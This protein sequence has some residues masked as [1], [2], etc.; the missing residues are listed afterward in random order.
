MWVKAN[1]NRLKLMQ[2]QKGGLF[3]ERVNFKII[4]DD[5]EFGLLYKRTAKWLKAYGQV[6]NDSS[7][8]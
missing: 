2:L 1:N 5:N 7:L 3:I 8:V 6:G 4:K